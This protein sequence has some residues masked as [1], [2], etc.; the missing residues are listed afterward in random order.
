MKPS[1][2]PEESRRLMA[3]ITEAVVG[4]DQ[5]RTRAA[6]DRILQTATA[7]THLHPTTGRAIECGC[8]IETISNNGQPDS[9]FYCPRDNLVNAFRVYRIQAIQVPLYLRVRYAYWRIEDL[10]GLG[11]F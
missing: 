10:R 6:V 9:E 5:E 3:D 11:D 7:T 1:T 2:S 8:R 4:Y